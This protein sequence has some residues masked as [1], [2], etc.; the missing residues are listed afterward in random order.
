MLSPFYTPPG[1]MAVFCKVSSVDTEK[2]LLDLLLER[3]EKLESLQLSLD[4]SG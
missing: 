4:A 2:M 1:L 3:L